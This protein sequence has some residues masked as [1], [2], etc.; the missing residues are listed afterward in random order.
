MPMV[1]VQLEHIRA[2]QPIR[3]ESQ[4]VCRKVDILQGLQ[5]LITT[6]VCLVWLVMIQGHRSDNTDNKDRAAVEAVSIIATIPL[7]IG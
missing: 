4:Q 5:A 1:L 3:E 7:T 6:P 2:L